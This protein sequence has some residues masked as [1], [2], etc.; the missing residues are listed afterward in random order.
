V[1]FCPALRVSW[2]VWVKFCV[3]DMHLPSLRNYEF[4]DSRYGG[5]CTLL[6]G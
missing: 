2:P 6:T 5:T 1:N 4:G 3:R